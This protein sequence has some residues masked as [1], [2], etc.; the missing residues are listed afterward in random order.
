MTKALAEGTQDAR[1]FFHSA[2]IAAAAGDKVEAARYSRLAWKSRQ[3]LY[4]SE[5][6]ELG[7]IMPGEAYSQDYQSNLNHN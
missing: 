7:R 4:P 6:E 5:R 1:L 3:M 2:V